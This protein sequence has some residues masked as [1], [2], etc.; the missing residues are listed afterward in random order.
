MKKLAIV[1]LLSVFMLPARGSDSVSGFPRVILPGDFAD[2][3]IVRDGA[4][5]YMTHSAF[6]YAPGFLV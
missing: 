3:T 4:D 5:Y 6:S 2:P 1:F